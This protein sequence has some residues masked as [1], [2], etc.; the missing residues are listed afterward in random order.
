M[1]ADRDRRGPRRTHAVLLHR[2]LGFRGPVLRRLG[3]VCRLSDDTR[4]ETVIVR[5]CPLWGETESERAAMQR[6]R[7]RE[8]DGQGLAT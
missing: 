4:Q 8:L 6:L 5:V 2:F 7:Q 3:D 1:V